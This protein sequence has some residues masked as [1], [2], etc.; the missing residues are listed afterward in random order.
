MHGSTRTIDSWTDTIM[1]QFAGGIAFSAMLESDRN[2]EKEYKQR[3][4][5]VMKVQS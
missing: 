1:V 5:M 3:K 2:R 4:V